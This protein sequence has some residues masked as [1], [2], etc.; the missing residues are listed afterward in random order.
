MNDKI[1]DT[2]EDRAAYLA[3]TARPHHD[4][5]GLLARRHLHN[6]LARLLEVR[7]EFTAQLPD[8]THNKQPDTS[9]NTLSQSPFITGPSDKRKTPM[10]F[11]KLGNTD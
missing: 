11:N 8:R 1:A 2:A 7:D 6:E 4:V 3:E 5:A 10:P 9:T